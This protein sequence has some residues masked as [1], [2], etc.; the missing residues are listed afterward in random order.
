MGIRINKTLG[1]GVELSQEEYENIFNDEAYDVSLEKYLDFL[2]ECEKKSEGIDPLGISLEIAELQSGKIA[3]KDSTGF[4]VIESTGNVSS[5]ED[6]IAVIIIPVSLKD[7]WHRYDNSIDYLEA[8]GME[9]QVKYLPYGVFPW[10]GI[11]MDK[12]NGKEIDAGS[13][14]FIRDS[15]QL[16]N[17]M[18]DEPTEDIDNM[19]N[20]EA[21]KVGFS[22]YAEYAENSV[23][24]V[25]KMLRALVEYLGVFSD[26]SI[27]NRLRPMLATYWD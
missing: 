17:A 10:N 22:S 21:V 4:D 5:E 23:P 25:P 1:W 13:V 6:K 9:P 7:E 19:L 27:V 26:D 14:R 12:K 20:K 15:E 8:E 3:F 2:K 24:Y 11:Y 16:K 18:G